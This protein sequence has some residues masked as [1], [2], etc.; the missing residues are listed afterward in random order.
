MSSKRVYSSYAEFDSYN[1]Y[2]SIFFSSF[3]C[4]VILDLSPFWTKAGLVVV[5]LL[6]GG[7]AALLDFAT[8]NFL[9]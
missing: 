5:F 4:F 9:V 3:A 6:E 7:E 1:N 2:L 8:T